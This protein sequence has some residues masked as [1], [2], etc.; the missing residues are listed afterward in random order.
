[1]PLHCRPPDPVKVTV[2]RVCELRNCRQSKCQT[3]I[4]RRLPVELFQKGQPLAVGVLGRGLTEDLR[5][6]QVGQGGKERDRAVVSYSSCETASDCS[7]A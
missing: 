7:R 6:I 4:R 3:D 5:L 1:M 2:E